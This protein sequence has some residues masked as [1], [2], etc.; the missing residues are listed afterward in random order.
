[1]ANVVKM[2]VKEWGE[3]HAR[4]WIF[5]SVC[6]KLKRH[7]W[8]VETKEICKYFD[9][10]VRCAHFLRIFYAFELL[11]EWKVKFLTDF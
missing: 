10:Y 2:C 8:G 9:N 4:I 3:M 1:M 6:N 5:K 7:V 11:C